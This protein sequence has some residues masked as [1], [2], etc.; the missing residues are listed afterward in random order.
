[1]KR[2]RVIDR[3]T[4]E[5]VG[6]DAINA[7][8]S[9]VGL[10]VVANQQQ[11]QRCHANYWSDRGEQWV[12]ETYS[13][14]SYDVKTSPEED[15]MRAELAKHTARLEASDARKSREF[16]GVLVNGTT[17]SF[18]EKD[19]NGLAMVATA[20]REAQATGVP[21]EALGTTFYF[22]NGATLNLTPANIGSVALAMLSACEQSFQQYGQDLATI[23]GK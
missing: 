14:A 13:L 8:E 1:M 5:V 23:E 17:I 11:W 20:F 10:I 15:L 9:F 19:R 2:Y 3:A 7:G 12:M 6:A 16:A 22:Q 4:G 21:A 18:M